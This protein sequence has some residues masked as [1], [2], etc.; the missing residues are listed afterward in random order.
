MDA[1]CL[2][3]GDCVAGVLGKKGGCCLRDVT[4]DAVRVDGST[5]PLESTWTERNQIVVLERRTHAVGSRLGI[6]SITDTVC[7]VAATNKIHY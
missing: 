2:S 1:D 5:S 4:E 7:Y 3:N 6:N